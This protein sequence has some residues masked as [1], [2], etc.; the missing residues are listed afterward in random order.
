MALYCNNIVG[1]ISKN[2]S[3]TKGGLIKNLYIA[4]FGQ[5]DT[6]TLTS[7]EITAITMKADPLT[8]FGAD[9]IWFQLAVKKNSSG[10]T[11]PAELGDSRF[12]NQT[13]AFSIE[14]FDT[15]TKIAFQNFLG[16]DVVFIGTTAEGTSHMMGRL[17]GAEMTEGSIGTGVANTD[18]VGGTATFVAY[19]IEVV[20]TIASGTTIEVLNED[21]VTVDV[22]T[23]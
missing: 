14:G 9:Y 11:N 18:L 4:N 19:E 17:S 7:D 22:V 23:L 6:T 15:A 2:C 20:R 16:S 5:L 8:T 21:G 3:P 13:L 10:F 1:N 12:W